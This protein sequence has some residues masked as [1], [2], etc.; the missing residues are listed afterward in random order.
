MNGGTEMNGELEKQIKIEK[1]IKEILR[2]KDEIFSRYLL[3]LS[4]NPATVKQE[5]ISKV[6]YF[7][8]HVSKLDS[9]KVSEEQLR[10]IT[11]EDIQIFLEETKYSS[12]SRVPKLKSPSTERMEIA[13]LKSFFD[14][15]QKI[16]VVDKNPTDTIKRPKLKK[17]SVTY[18][19]PDEIDE[20]RDNMYRGIGTISKKVR[21]NRRRWANRNVSIL[22]LGCTMGL[23]VSAIS[24]INVAD[25]DFDEMTISVTEKGNVTKK[26]W[27][28]TDTA[29]CI[30]DWMV[31][32]DELLGDKETDALFLS[33]RKERI[34]VKGI[35]NIISQYTA[36]LDKHITPNQM[37]SS[38]ATNLY[39][40]TGDIY[41]VK[42]ILGHKNIANTQ[43]YVK[44]AEPL[45]TRLKNAADILEKV[46]GGE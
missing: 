12:R 31:D 4:T 19:D 34:T 29:K 14:F 44:R 30:H 42:E 39:V 37:R 22:M 28:G 18:M 45:E 5:Y 24:A 36:T 13:A 27:M 21:E 6:L 16:G 46:Y 41:L 40:Q 11:K 32:R 15:L 20:V 2:D 38:C 3:N 43:K 9:R 25:V 10:N 7:F 8:E 23:R 1:R 26:V 35:E 33:S 17:T